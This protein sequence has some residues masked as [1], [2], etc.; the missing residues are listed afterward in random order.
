MHS[1]RSI[2]LQNTRKR[3]GRSGVRAVYMNQRN[4][5]GMGWVYFIASDF[6]QTVKIG[7]SALP[8]SRVFYID[9]HSAT[10]VRLV[11]M[12]EG[13]LADERDLHRRF[14]LHRLRHEWF[15]FHDDVKSFIAQLRASGVGST[16]RPADLH[17]YSCEC[18]ACN[19][20]PYGGAGKHPRFEIREVKP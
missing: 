14:A 1:T 8:E 11:W 3:N 7:W 20:R 13:T 19:T 10:P 6:A 15:V 16:E 4:R 18:D 12:F 17:R 5:R 2:S 9:R